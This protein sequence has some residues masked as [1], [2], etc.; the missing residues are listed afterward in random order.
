MK[1]LGKDLAIG[2]RII[3]ADD[4]R[5]VTVKEIC[6]GIVPGT[7]MV[8]WRDP[9]FEWSSVPFEAEIELAN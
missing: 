9:D 2:D 3:I 6:R 5:T 4:A 1:K 7:R 8:V